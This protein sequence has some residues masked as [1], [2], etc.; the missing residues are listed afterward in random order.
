MPVDLHRGVLGVDVGAEAQ[1]WIV[2][3]DGSGEGASE[4]ER[5]DASDAAMNSLAREKV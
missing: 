2:D 3:R 4:Q 1:I 5:R